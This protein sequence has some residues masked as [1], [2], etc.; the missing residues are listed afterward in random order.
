VL[1]YFVAFFGPLGWLLAI[2]GYVAVWRSHSTDRT[3][4]GF[5]PILGAVT[6]ATWAVLAGQINVHYTLQMTMVVLVGI[7]LLVYAL[8]L[9][10][11]GDAVRGVAMAGV[12]F[13]AVLNLTMTLGPAILSAPAALA[14]LL[15]PSQRPLVRGDLDELH[16]LVDDL[17][18][19]VPHRPIFVAASSFVFNEEILRHAE[20][21]RHGAESA[22]LD[23]LQ[24]P[25]V[26]SRDAYPLSGIDLAEVV[27]LAN[28]AQY[29]MAPDQQRVVAVA[30]DAFDQKWDIA[31]DFQRQPGVYRLQDGVAVT[32]F[33]RVRPSSVL[34][35]R[36]TLARIEEFVGRVPGTQPGWVVV[37]SYQS[38]ASLLRN[39]DGTDTI[40]A[41][42]APAG[43]ATPTV[44]LYGGP[45]ASSVS[46]LL[47]FE[48]SACPGVTLRVTEYDAGGAALSE[49]SASRRPTD[50]SEF[51]VD[52]SGA[53]ADFLT[54]ELDGF[55]VASEVGACRVTLASVRVTPAP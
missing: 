29:H 43:A 28:P 36:R 35:T 40:S 10:L 45:W 15:P 49:Q 38:D 50:T 23:V 47:S 44:L 39:G 51:R 18:T 2:G 46:G 20:I 27:V 4:V 30:H 22:L 19:Q 42:P 17:R 7:A 14:P 54:L 25:A 33:Q 8:F 3:K 11:R 48:D 34:V 9:R 55:D 52:L 5:L 21:E 37:N 24:V 12:A 1:G 6:L 32:V 53:P 13:L 41:R 16:R 26:D 31:R